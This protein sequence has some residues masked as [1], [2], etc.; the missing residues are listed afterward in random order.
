MLCND[1]FTINWQQKLHQG[2]KLSKNTPLL[3][4]YRQF[5][6]RLQMSGFTTPLKKSFQAWQVPPW[7]RPDIPLIYFQDRL[8]CVAGHY[9]HP[10]FQATTEHG[11]GWIPILV[12]NR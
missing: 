7:E 9:I 6:E 2:L 12:H 10:D 4:R 11:M 1:R 8:I 3:I 5:G